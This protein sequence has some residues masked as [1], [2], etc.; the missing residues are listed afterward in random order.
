MLYI[1]AM[2]KLILI[3][4][5]FGCTES[6]SQIIL[7]SNS[8][9]STCGN[10]NGFAVT[11][12]TGGSPPYTYAWNN[13]PSLGNLATGLCAGLH[14]VAVSD[15]VNPTVYDTIVVTDI[16]G[17]II[18]SITTVN[19][20][21]G[22]N[23]TM[24]AW[25]SGAAQ[26]YTFQWNDP[27]LQTVQTATGLCAGNYCVVVTDSNGCSASS[28][29]SIITITNISENNNK[30]NISIFPNPT[31]GQLSISL[32]KGT[33]TALTLRNSLGQLLLSDKLKATNQVV[34]DLSAYP[35]GIYFLQLEV[36]G[37]VITKKIIKK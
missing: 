37:Q 17:P 29:D 27:L 20:S 23:G 30:L 8:A 14:I 6:F 2:K 9:S 4:L 22:C 12:A 11:A 15:G 28:C 1:Y 19:D 13:S 5:L 18:D 26:L 32:E 35:T 34:L 10:C 24:T 3:L 21:G 7:T 16:A 36:D 33:A 31:T 25:V